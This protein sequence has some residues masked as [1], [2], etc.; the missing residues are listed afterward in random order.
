VRLPLST[1][2]FVQQAI[3][4]RRARHR[5][6]DFII[7]A[8]RALAVALIVLAFA[9]PLIG[10]RPLVSASDAA[11][12]ERVVILDVSQSMAAR[13][14]GI[15]LFERARP[16]AARYLS[17]RGGL[18]ANL[19]LAGSRPR[20]VFE[21]PSNNFAALR[22]ELDRAAVLPQRLD[23]QSAVT[24]A[25]EMLSATADDETRRELIV[26]S[27]FQRSN[28][29]A[30]DF[31]PLPEDTQIQL[32][33]VSPADAPANL[34][35]LR[36][37]AAGRVERGKDTRV[38]VEVGNFSP[39]PRSVQVELTLGPKTLRLEGHCPA[40]SATTL[41][42]DAALG[43]TGWQ[44]GRARLVGVEDA[45]SADDARAFVLEV[46]PA[47]VFGLI[48]R[49]R[50]ENKPMSSYFL[51]RALAPLHRSRTRSQQRVVRIDPSRI[52]RETLGPVDLIVL[53]HPGKL[54]E[55]ALNLLASL[56]Q[57]GRPMLYVAAEPVDAT[58][59][60]RLSDAVG[61][62]LQM[63]VE[64]MPPPAGQPRR[65]LFLA[66]IR[67][68]VPPFSVFG[69]ELTAL[70]SG[71]RFAGGLTSRRLESGLADDVLA[72]Y[73]DRSAG[74]VLTACGAGALAVL[75]V[76]LSRSNLAGSPMFVPL[77]GELSERLLGR[78]RAGGAVACGETLVAYLP[79]EA[80]PI[81]GLRIEADADGN[82]PLGELE[83]DS[84]GA[85][86]KWNS[87]G[88]PGV[89][90]VVRDRPVF[91][92]AAALDPDESDLRSLKPEV[93]ET[94]LSGGRTVRFQSAAD[95]DE[96]RDDR[97]VW[98]AVACMGCLIVELVALRAFRT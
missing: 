43:E 71:L 31:S 93:L 40:R 26:I 72:T 36:V 42:T 51:E 63:P 25:A 61:T 82:A 65:D 16:L 68:D 98:L 70:S 57:R 48:T 39:T 74:L 4:Q 35:V 60:R 89:Y 5:L 2:R 45:L 6:R 62:G 24:A 7:L 85:L 52:D 46:R 59:L 1:L 86:W 76:D 18:R 84:G 77:I 91:A 30:V 15:E 50:D 20:A 17:Y 81:A 29:S 83:E 78:R 21:R 22:D 11:E 87:V 9:R 75:N 28:W 80:G 95:P 32:E 14:G 12:A 96:P 66:D 19:I 97:W 88:P 23:I 33:S 47:T 8:L 69:D 54:G 90:R 58:N 53:D 92:L 73:S 41:V 49:Q 56:L 27:D 34:G 55:E 64:F 79:A 3:R 10:A 94:R 38:E 37:A 44:S 13:D 67:R